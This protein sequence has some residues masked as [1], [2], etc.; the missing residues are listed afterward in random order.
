MR[1]SFKD[2]QERLAAE[3][4]GMADILYPL[5]ER[6]DPESLVSLTPDHLLAGATAQNYDC[7]I[8]DAAEAINAE[9]GKRLSIDGLAHILSLAQHI[10]YGEWSKPLRVYSVHY[11]MAETLH[12]LLPEVRPNA[13]STSV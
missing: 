1:E 5:F 3:K 4:A 12:P 11:R 9:G 13:N 2:E 7:V 10:H 8:Q 6:F